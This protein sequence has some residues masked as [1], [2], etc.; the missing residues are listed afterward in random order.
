V[1]IYEHMIE[2]LPSLE[3]K[4]NKTLSS[5]G[6]DEHFRI[7]CFG[8]GAAEAVAFGAF[9]RYL[10]DPNSDDLAQST[11]NAEEGTAQPG[12]VSINTLQSSIVIPPP[13]FSVRL[14][15]VAQWGEVVEKLHQGLITP[16]S[17]S[18]Y[19]SAAAKAANRSLLAPTLISTSFEAVDVLDLSREQIASRIGEKPMLLTLLFTLN[20]LYTSSL[21]KTTAFL[22]NLTLAVPKVRYC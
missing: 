1:D 9:L 10:L 8:G 22:L 5:H 21:S 3:K 18:K 15:D 11:I 14:F 7:V 19:A 6:D 12:E 17:L 16:P 13:L 2:L 20:E 4:D